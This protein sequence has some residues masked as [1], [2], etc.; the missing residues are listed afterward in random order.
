M[1]KINDDIDKENDPSSSSLLVKSSQ[2]LEKC[3]NCKQINDG[4]V[5]TQVTYQQSPIN[6]VTWGGK[7]EFVLSC[8]S[9]A[10]GLGNVWRFPY[11]CHKNG[12]GAF[13][14][15]YVIML[16]LVGLPLFFLEFAF[17]QFASLGPISIWNVSPLFKGIGYAMVAVSWIMSLYYNVIVAQALL[18]LFY[19][20]TRELPWSHCNNTWNHPPTYANGTIRENITFA[21]PICV[22]QTRNLTEMF[23]NRTM[24]E[25]MTFT[26]PAEDFFYNHVVRKSGGIDE[27]GLPSWQLSLVL[28]LAWIICAL[29]LIRGVQSLG[30]VSYFTALFPYLILTILL[31]R[32]LMLKGS[33][34]GI[35]YYLTPQFDRLKDPRVWV[36]AATQ[37]FFS[38]GCCSGSLIAMSS[39]NPF[40]NNC[41]RDAI[42]VACINC[43]TS[44]YAGFVVFANLGF[45][46]EQKNV[47][48]DNVA[49][50][51]PGLAFVVYPEALSQM[52]FPAI[53]SVFF[54]FMLSTVGMGS[55]FAIVETVMSGVEDELRRLGLLTKT[56]LKYVFR[57][58][59]CAVSCLLGI[60]MV[61]PGGYFLLFLIDSAM[62]GYPLMFIGVVEIIIICYSYGLKQ[63]RKDI[64]LMINARPNWYWRISWLITTPGI[65][66][67]LIIFLLVSSNE[68]QLDNYIYPQWAQSLY[69]LTSSFPILCIPFWFLYK[70]C[71]EGGWILFKEFLKP[72]NEWGPAQDEHRA[73]FI[74]MIR[75]NDSLRHNASGSQMCI[76][77]SYIPPGIGDPE[78]GFSG[79]D[80][81]GRKKRVMI[82]N[83]SVALDTEGGFFQSKLSVAEKL[84]MAH[85]KELAKRSGVDL[86]HL[87]TDGLTA[88]Q[89]ALA[90]MTAA[91]EVQPYSVAYEGERMA[92]RFSTTDAP[93]INFDRK[94]SNATSPVHEVDS[95]SSPPA[96][97]SGSGDV[98]KGDSDES[99]T[100]TT[101]SAQGNSQ[102]QQQ[103]QQQNNE[104]EKK[105]E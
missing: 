89:L 48:M 56:Y 30:K 97:V 86:N 53:W 25:N 26:S 70:Y 80:S 54:F 69:H 52:P 9:Y 72:V 49:K 85:T 68:L 7:I 2:L 57:I 51:G 5:E 101:R 66:V 37:I 38:L 64:E 87:D 46:A 59:L 75:S 12:G 67:A 60:P 99:S 35:L 45:M 93:T 96:S 58:G 4:D 62:S 95:R 31:V 33:L 32:S 42:I 39:Y 76:S 74:S 65:S 36:D 40:K 100:T 23:P 55:Q 18:Y 34:Q 61:C 1:E 50:A 84:T 94:T 6:R 8:I 21:S 16:G 90:A 91:K 28:I 81:V 19:S 24:P 44:I 10:V 20:F 43:L 71:R 17:G 98:K 29:V 92:D 3:T 102:Q 22:D 13:L 77:S 47:S 88:S 104:V 73:E 11:L 63:F 78:N 105:I 41:C 79:G 103:R 82:G 14:V 27:M 83:S 15:P